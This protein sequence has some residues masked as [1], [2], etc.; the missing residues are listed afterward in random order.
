M[1]ETFFVIRYRDGVPL[2]RR[3]HEHTIGR[4]PTYGAALIE[5]VEKPNPGDLEVLERQERAA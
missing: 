1:A 4:F 5:L 3:K 2:K